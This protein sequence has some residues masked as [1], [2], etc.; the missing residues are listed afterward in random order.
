MAATITVKTPFGGTGLKF[1]WE[2]GKVKVRG[3]RDQLMFWDNLNSQGMYGMYGHI[4]NF[5]NT[6]IT[7]VVIALQN[8]VPAKDISL[9]VE[10]KAQRDKEDQEAKPFPKG[11]VS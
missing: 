6:P 1:I 8:R 9:N 7:D 2:E 10:A 3:T 5:Q 11:A 4:V